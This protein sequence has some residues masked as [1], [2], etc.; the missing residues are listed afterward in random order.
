MTKLDFLKENIE[1]LEYEPARRAFLNLLESMDLLGMRHYAA[2]CVT[3]VT[4]TDEVT[5]KRIYEAL[6]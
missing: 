1:N 6:S 5:L 2:G 4:G 3:Y